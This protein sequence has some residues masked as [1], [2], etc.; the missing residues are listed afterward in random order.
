VTNDDAVLDQAGSVGS[1]QWSYGRELL[2]HRQGDRY[3]FIT[4]HA[5]VAQQD[6]CL[7]VL[8]AFTVSSV[9]FTGGG[10]HAGVGDLLLVPFTILLIPL[11]LKRNRLPRSY[12]FVATAY[13]GFCALS[14]AWT[15]HTSSAI[16]K[17]V[18][19]SEFMWI[20][21]LV[22]AYASSVRGVALCLKAYIYASTL[23]ATAAILYG[24]ATRR[25]EDLFF[26]NYQKNYLGAVVGNSIP[27]IAGYAS[28]HEI[29]RRRIGICLGLN[30]VALLMSTSRGAMLGAGV[31]LG[32][33]LL[34]T[35]HWRQAIAWAATIGAIYLV[36]TSFVASGYGSNITNASTTSSAYSRVIIY[37][38][39]ELAISG[40]ALL[41]SGL[42][43]FF[44]DLPQISFEQNDPN[45]VFLLNLLEVG[46]VGTVLFVALI[47]VVFALGFGNAARFRG[48]PTYRYLNA[49]FLGGFASELAHI[50]VDVSWVRGTGTYM[51]A[52][53]GLVMALR[54]LYTADVTLV[55]NR[56]ASPI[57]HRA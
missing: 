31:G 56:N 15:A 6:V 4:R 32:V 52:C 5:G 11:I 37:Q 3:G 48:D 2:S 9:T 27:L 12:L 45:N 23:I 57:L 8:L 13:L 33:V 21:P 16:G 49:A 51:F 10:V 42:N 55:A 7:A 29:S 34:T 30:V 17:L 35:G 36:F 43:S 53:A 50:Q 40:H 41:G 38:D 1:Q 22:F 18:Q 14:L 46:V 26:L 19:Y 20:V 47:G 28:T 54:R 24:I 44:V 39:A 25:F